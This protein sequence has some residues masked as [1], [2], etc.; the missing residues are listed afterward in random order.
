[1]KRTTRV[2]WIGL[3]L[4]ATGMLP[5]LWA[6]AE[7]TGGVLDITRHWWSSLAIA[8]LLLGVAITAIGIARLNREG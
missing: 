4:I 8:P 6:A 7:L 1:M 3:I 2:A 5:A